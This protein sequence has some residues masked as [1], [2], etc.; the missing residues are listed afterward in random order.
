GEEACGRGLQGRIEVASPSEE[1][2]GNPVEGD[3]ACIHRDDAVRCGEAAL[4][5]VFGEEHSHAP[6]LVEAAQQ[7]DQLVAGDGVEL[8]GGLVEEDQTRPGD[9][10]GGDG[11][12]LQL[13]A[14]EGVD[15]APE[16]VR[17]SQGEGDLLDGAGAVGGLVAAHLQ[18]LLDLG[19]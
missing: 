18:R 9:Q 13:T 3:V 7:P 2:G 5:T 10:G 15:G 6:L 14:G 19:G 4:E 16:Q 11:G 1:L 12:A 8:G 17:D